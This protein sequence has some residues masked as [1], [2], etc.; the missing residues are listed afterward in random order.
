MTLTIKLDNSQRVRLNCPPYVLTDDKTVLLDVTSKYN[1]QNAVFVFHNG[2]VKATV[3]YQRPLRVPE[4]VLFGGK[5]SISVYLYVDGQIVKDWQIYPLI[6]KEVE[7]KTT[8][9][10]WCDQV[11]KKL[12]ELDER[13]KIIL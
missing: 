4:R 8:L 11:E 7:D 10:D 2:E 9:F 3:D 12:A 5:I 13:T 6:V 1:L